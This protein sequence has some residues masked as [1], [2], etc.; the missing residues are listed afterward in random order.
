MSSS[1][2]APRGMETLNESPEISR[3][4]NKANTPYVSTAQVISEVQV[5]YI[6]QVFNV[7]GVEYCFK[8]GKLDAD[9]VVK[10]SGVQIDDGGTSLS[11]TYSSDKIVGLLSDTVTSQDLET[12]IDKTEKGSA[13]GVGTLDVNGKQPLSEVSDAL[14][15]NLKWYGLFNGIVVT[16]SPLASLNNNSIPT[17]SIENVGWYFIAS[18]SYL[19]N[20]ISYIEGDWLISNG[21]DYVKI[22]NT[23]A[24][25]SVAG[26]TGVI[27]VEG[28]KTALAYDAKL[29]IT[30]TTATKNSKYIAIGTF[31]ITDFA[32]PVKGNEYEVF[33]RDGAITVGGITYPAGTVIKRVFDTTW[34][35]YEYSVNKTFVYT[36]NIT[37]SLSGSKSFGLLTN[38]MTT[39]R[40]GKTVNE[41]IDSVLVEYLFPSF[42]SL[43]ITS[44]LQVVEVG[45]I[46]SGIKSFAFGFSNVGN[47]KENSISIVHITNG[48]AVLAT[49][50]PKNSPQSADIG[51]VSFAQ[52][53]P[54]FQDWKATAENTNNTVISSGTFRVS[55]IY[56]VFYGKGATTPTINQAL[57]NDG[58]KALVDSTGTVNIT[59][60]ASGEFLWFAIPRVSTSKTKWFVSELNQGGIGG[61]SNLFGSETFLAI[62]S[63]AVMWNNVEYKFYVSNN[64]TSTTGAMQLKN[65]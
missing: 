60:G 29:I 53:Q 38:G 61:V 26:L 59:F 8:L 12:K 49:G 24:V 18:S 42:S 44:Q 9:L 2:A 14:L 10:T 34:K 33:V 17:P 22:D 5:R 39:D 25:S 58:T 16:D 19:I 62:N 6:G 50:K 45:T 46:I 56:P 7:D 51:I 13:S 1:I 30:T 36:D 41:F 57:I 15:G 23:D 4:Y 27:T 64:A 54:D 52:L 35:S 21:L 37:M 11:K 32:N 20:G 48:N 31:A 55:K 63:P 65:N 3:Y 47:V 40:I 43:T 28:L